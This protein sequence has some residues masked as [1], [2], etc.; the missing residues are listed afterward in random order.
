MAPWSLPSPGTRPDTRPTVLRHS[1]ITITFV[2]TESP[3]SHVRGNENDASCLSRMRTSV[4][5][6]QKSLSVQTVSKNVGAK[7]ESE[8]FL[9]TTRKKYK[10]ARRFGQ[11]SVETGV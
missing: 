5:F 2:E 3:I 4:W 11:R 6:P 10:L 8:L 9:H 7:R 1:S